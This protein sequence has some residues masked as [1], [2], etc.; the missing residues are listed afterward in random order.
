[1]MKKLSLMIVLSIIIMSVI[2]PVYAKSPDGELRGPGSSSG[3]IY[4]KYVVPYPEGVY[5]PTKI[6]YVD[7]EWSGTLY[8]K[9]VSHGSGKA[10][11]IY[12]GWI[13]QDSANPYDKNG[14]KVYLEKLGDG[15]RI[16]D[17][18]SNPLDS[19]TVLLDLTK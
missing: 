10:Y 18:R 4:K 8:L 16:R 14:S 17:K 1:M 15:Y 19:D 6:D 3:K 12:E 13:Y 7:G 11:A 5:I 2:I 9:T